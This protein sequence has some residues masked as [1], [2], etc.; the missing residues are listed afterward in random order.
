M[1]PERG[2]LQ[3]VIIA[4][5]VLFPYTVC[6]YPTDAIRDRDSFRRDELLVLKLVDAYFVRDNGPKYDFGLLSIDTVHKTGH[7]PDLCS[8]RIPSPCLPVLPLD[9][10]AGQQRSP[11]PCPFLR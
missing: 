9:I 3:L 4:N 10:P 2:L 11:M 7:L 8:I 1:K 5:R 6:P